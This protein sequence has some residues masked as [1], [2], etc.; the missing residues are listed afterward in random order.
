MKSS[1]AIFGNLTIDDLVFA[2]GSTRWAVP[3][4]SAVYAAYGASL[5]T[6]SA[7]IVAPLGADYPAA[8]LD[9]RIDF[10]RCPRLPRTLRNW[11]LYEEDGSRHFISRRA[12]RDWME[13][14]P[15]AGDALSGQ[16]IAAHI[17][18]LPHAIA[19]GL[20]RE[21]R[22]S[23]TRMIS[24][25]LDDHDL[26]G[27][28]GVE[29]IVELLGGIDLFLPSLDDACALFGGTEAP[30]VLRRMR[31]VAPDVPVIAV[32]C[33]AEGVIAHAASAH[34][35]IRVPAAP[36]ELID[37]TGAGDAFCGGM[38]AGLAQTGILSEALLWGVVS[39]SFCIEGLGFAS[40]IA[41]T[42]EEAASRLFS[43]Q[44]LIETRAI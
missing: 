19:A 3:G 28:V 26:A 33:G 4:G 16:Q 27:R 36:V 18:P 21:L 2:D 43:L 30:E 20:S 38:L 6:G 9:A 29:A 42:S 22:R 24:L 41:A 35:W 15:K 34:E 1:I 37:A 23:G 10:S 25:D 32:K 8:L 40:L 5:W 31:S 13:F 7:S 44:P 12:T 17:A 11:G 39:A 14:S